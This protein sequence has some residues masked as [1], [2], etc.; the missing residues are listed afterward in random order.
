MAKEDQNNQV[1]QIDQVEPVPYF[2]H[3]GILTRM[4]E[5]NKKLL[6]ARWSHERRSHKRKLHGADPERERHDR[7]GQD[8]GTAGA[9][10]RSPDA[11]RI[12]RS[13]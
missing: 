11:E 8:R 3:E 1:D 9:D 7:S 10:Q 2:I 13:A 6:I 12:V 5:C 4:A